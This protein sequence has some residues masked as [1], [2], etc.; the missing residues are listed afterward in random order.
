M[1]SIKCRRCPLS[2]AESYKQRKNKTRFWQL[3]RFCP[4]CLNSSL[5]SFCFSPPPFSPNIQDTKTGLK[6]HLGDGKTN[7]YTYMLSTPKKIVIS[8]MFWLAAGRSC[9][10][11]FS[12]NQADLLSEKWA[13]YYGIIICCPNLLTQ[14]IISWIIQ[15]LTFLKTCFAQRPSW[16]KKCFK[17]LWA[18]IKFKHSW[19]NLIKEFRLLNFNYSLWVVEVQNQHLGTASTNRLGQW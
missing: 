12:T 11:I 2:M 19:Q 7:K 13:I 14:I 3:S 6:L 5:V 17:I 10:S 9:P 8:S 1:I 4:Y 16:A 18:L 15:K